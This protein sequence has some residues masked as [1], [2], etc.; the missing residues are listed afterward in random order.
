[1]QKALKTFGIAKIT[2]DLHLKRGVKKKS[3]QLCI[4]MNWR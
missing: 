4:I 3:F 2:Q 1:M